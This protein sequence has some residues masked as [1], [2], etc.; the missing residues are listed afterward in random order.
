MDDP[1]VA[2]EVLSAIN[3]LG[4]ATAVDDFGTGYSSLTYL[5]QFPIDVVKIDRSFVSRMGADTRDASIVSVVVGLAQTLQLDVVAEGVETKEQLDTLA[6]L[7]CSYAQG[8]Y[9]AKAMP[10]VE[11]EK[12]LINGFDS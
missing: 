1:V 7:D 5:C 10:A 4:V 11:A 9:F 6:A 2:Q 3:K 12:L 8:Y